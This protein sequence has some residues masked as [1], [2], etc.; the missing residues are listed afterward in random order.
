MP[1]N[2]R[3]SEFESEKRQIFICRFSLALSDLSEPRFDLTCTVQLTDNFVIESPPF[4]VGIVRSNC[5][6]NQV[7]GNEDLLPRCSTETVLIQMGSRALIATHPN[8]VRLRA[9]TRGA[10]VVYAL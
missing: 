9:F 4:P 8:T 7:G 2:G 6:A 10:G 5:F 3:I 1:V